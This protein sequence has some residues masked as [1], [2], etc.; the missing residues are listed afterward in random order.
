MKYYAQIISSATDL[1]DPSSWFDYN[2][3]GEGDAALLR[4]HYYAS[5]IGLEGKPEE[6][7]VAVA[8]TETEGAPYKVYRV[9]IDYDP[10]MTVEE[11]S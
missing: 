1:P 2:A 5:N 4:V 9:E 3:F 6:L 7:F 10:T 8:E 11:V